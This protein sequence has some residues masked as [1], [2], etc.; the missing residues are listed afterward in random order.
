MVLSVSVVPGR[1]SGHVVTLV[2]LVMVV[3]GA[4]GS[5]R[6][7]AETIVGTRMISGGPMGPMVRLTVPTNHSTFLSTVQS[8]VSF[9]GGDTRPP[10]T[11][12]PEVV[13]ASSLET[14]PHRSGTGRPELVTASVPETALDL[15]QTPTTSAGVFNHS[16]AAHTFFG[17]EDAV[18][19]RPVMAR[20]ADGPQFR[21]VIEP[22]RP[23]PREPIVADQ[24]TVTAATQ[25]ITVEESL[26]CPQ[27]NA[28]W[29]PTR[30]C[31]PIGKQGQWTRR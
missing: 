6:R 2:A 17:P 31:V 4:A 16:A 29:P 22:A 19:A 30:Q 27:G 23:T 28:F 26:H 13:T 1:R 12:L 7:A 20:R 10:T 8:V 18:T 9:G 14:S 15:P 5:P 25:T 21:R 24:E 11:D 3:T